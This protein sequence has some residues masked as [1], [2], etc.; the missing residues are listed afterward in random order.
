MTIGTT[1]VGVSTVRGELGLSFSAGDNIS[2]KDMNTKHIAVD[3]SNTTDSRFTL[4]KK[5]GMT[6]TSDDVA[7]T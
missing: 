1:N 2:I 3:L 5:T 7:T 4:T 6:M